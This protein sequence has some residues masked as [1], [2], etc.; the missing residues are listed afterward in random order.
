MRGWQ[1]WFPTGIVELNNLRTVDDAIYQYHAQWCWKPDFNFNF[2]HM[3]VPTFIVL[4][5]RTQV[6][7]SDKNRVIISAAFMASKLTADIRFRKVAEVTHR[8]N[9]RADPWNQHPT[10][11]S[12]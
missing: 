6:A 11:R 10:D 2:C 9:R 1:T 4:A 8:E 7:V 12:L 3:N 5:T